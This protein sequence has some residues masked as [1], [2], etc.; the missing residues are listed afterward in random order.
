MKN[1][2]S[3]IELL[4]SHKYLTHYHIFE[5]KEGDY[6]EIPETLSEKLKEGLKKSGIEKL[7]SHQKKAFSLIEKGKNIVI[8]T[9]TASGKS[10]CYNLPIL[11]EIEKNPSTKCFYFFPT[12]ALSRDQSKSVIE[13][14]EK[15]NIPLRCEVYDGDTPSD[16]REGI[17]KNA[18]IIITNPDMLHQAILPHHPMWRRVIEN[19]KFIVI[20]EVHIYTG[21]F[22]SHFANVLRRLKRICEFYQAKPQFICCSATIANP[23]ELAENLVEEKFELIDE[24]GAPSSR[25]HFF[26]INPPIVNRELG[27]RKSYVDITVLMGKEFLERDIPTITFARTRLAVEVI[28]KYLK[29]RTKPTKKHKISAYRGGYLPNLRREIERK[30]KNKDISLIVSTNALE[31][32]IDIGELQ[33]CII[34]GYPGTISSTLQQAGR[35]GRKKDDSLAV[36]IGSNFA[37]DQFI[38]SNP[39]Y[40][41]K[42]SPEHARI[43]PD[44]PDI[45]FNHLCC[46]IYELP[47][48]EGERFGETEIEDLLT[49]MEE[50]ELVNKFGKKWHWISDSYPAA[51]FSLR[52]VTNDNFVV[53]DITEK[54][55]KVIA[56]VDYIAAHTTIYPQAIY[57]VQGRLYQV[58]K[59]DY[60]N[61]KAYV[62]E[63]MAEYYTDAID[64]T[65]VNILQVDNQEKAT[66]FHNNLGEI[67]VLTTITGF[68]KI[69]F[70]TNENIGYGKINIPDVEMHTT[71][72]WLTIDDSI[73]EQMGI[74]KSDFTE[75]LNGFLYSMKNISS[76]FLMCDTRDLGT[77][78]QTDD[79]KEN[80]QYSLFLYD[81]YPGGI[82]LSPQIYKLRESIFDG[83]KSLVKSC[84]CSHGCPSCIGIRNGENSNIK[85]NVI[86]LAS[87]LS[88]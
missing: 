8:T 58:E 27:I 5:K 56:E 59:L 63:V 22:G 34:A 47:F 32:G 66:F 70:Y 33:G 72:F 42:S 37:V 39:D 83:V 86:A 30:M 75:T 78:T 1:T 82:G 60:E 18:Q 29:D 25:K 48:K 62:R 85:S 54:R 21:V 77:S 68:K 44:N 15:S 20:D 67:H 45:L 40:L 3:L 80:F 69:K 7:Y 71:S 2:E 36:L 10:L 26:F 43:N 64:H 13:L 41:F 31:L 28:T 38:M 50:V 49:K 12:K 55:N 4:K 74:S 73:R 87:I 17:R 23:L 24:N 79:T 53:I 76:I 65:V 84:K 16:V 61:R 46:A 11:N 88:K 35:A 52:S 6:R 14:A 81:A 19:L 57:L 9:P 51:T